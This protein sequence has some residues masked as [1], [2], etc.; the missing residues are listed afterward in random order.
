MCGVAGML[1]ARPIDPPVL[2]GMAGRIRH[3]GPDDDGVWI[4]EGGRIGFAHRR[5]SIVDLSPAGHQPMQSADG[6]FTLSYNGEIYNHAEIRREI[7]AGFGPIAWRGHSDTETLVEAI[8]RGGVE[9]AVRCWAG[10]V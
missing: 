3:R 6:R 8:A 10:T 1:S 5:L 7:D 4:E 2:L 9:G